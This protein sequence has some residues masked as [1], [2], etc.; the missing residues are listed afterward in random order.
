MLSRSVRPAPVEACA[1]RRQG[2]RKGPLFFGRREKNGAST[3]SARTGSGFLCG[4]VAFCEPKSLR[5]RHAEHLRLRLQAS[6]RTR[7]GGDTVLQRLRRLR[8]FA[9][10]DRKSAGWGKRVPVP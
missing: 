9:A 3:G 6:R 1:E 5:P 2:S 10:R 4:F 7:V 8:P